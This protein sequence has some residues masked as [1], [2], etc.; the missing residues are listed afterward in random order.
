MVNCITNPV[1]LKKVLTL[2]GVSGIWISYDNTQ[3]T[4]LLT[5]WLTQMENGAANG[6]EY[7]AR[8]VIHDKI[9]CKMNKWLYPTNSMAIKLLN[10]NHNNKWLF[11]KEQ[12]YALAI[13]NLG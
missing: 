5:P 8:D 2:V 3:I 4:P 10:E 1:W 12:N 13:S 11:E 6:S 9:M 7:V